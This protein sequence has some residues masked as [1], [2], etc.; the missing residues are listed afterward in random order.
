LAL[1][2]MSLLLGDVT[3]LVLHFSLIDLRKFKNL[4][5]GLSGKLY[6]E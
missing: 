4:I 3:L 5:A 1:E 2:R 6:S